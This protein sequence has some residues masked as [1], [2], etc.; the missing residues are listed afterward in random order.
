[1]NTTLQRNRLVPP[2]DGATER[3]A[4]RVTRL[5]SIMPPAAGIVMGNR[6]FLRAWAAHR[7]IT[8]RTVGAQRGS[9]AP[10]V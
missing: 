8:A 3:S 1:M 9:G 10:F 5:S 6:A 4:L 7:A 2:A